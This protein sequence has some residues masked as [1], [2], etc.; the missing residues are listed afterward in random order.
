MCL[1]ATGGQGTFKFGDYLTYRLP[2]ND[3]RSQDLIV[4][5]VLTNAPNATI[6]NVTSS[7]TPDYITLMLVSRT[8]RLPQL[9]H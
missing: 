2:N 8:A 4:L 6:L 3:S 1:L 5:R 7:E 9:H